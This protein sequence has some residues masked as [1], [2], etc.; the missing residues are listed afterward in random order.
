M[1]IEIDDLAFVIQHAVLGVHL[2][3][4]EASKPDPL[5]VMELIR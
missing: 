1:F 2:A 4:S 5:D 3:A